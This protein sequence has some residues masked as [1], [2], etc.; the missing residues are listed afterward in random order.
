MAGNRPALDVPFFRFLYGPQ[1]GVEHL[2]IAEFENMA[3]RI[4][5]KGFSAETIWMSRLLLDSLSELGLLDEQ[6]LAEERIHSELFYKDLRGKHLREEVSNRVIEK[7]AGK[8]PSHC[9]ILLRVGSLF[10]F[11]RISHILSR[12]DGPVRCVTV[13]PYPGSREGQML[14]F[15]GEDWNNYYRW[16]TI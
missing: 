4:R 1:D 14:W 9:A 3:R 13:I 12:I 15:S 11:V 2:C 5:A 6:I 10:P 8:P 16:E 7:L